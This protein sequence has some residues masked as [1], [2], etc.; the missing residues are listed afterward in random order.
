VVG[1]PTLTLFLYLSAIEHDSLEYLFLAIEVL[2]FRHR[3]SELILNLPGALGIAM[4]QVDRHH[5][6]GL[7]RGD[8]TAVMI[9]DVP[10]R[11]MCIACGPTH[12]RVE[13]R[14][15]LA[16]ISR[17]RGTAAMRVL[18]EFSTAHQLL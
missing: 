2:R 4:Q 11:A 15:D 8:V 10:G 9:G 1:T 6:Q 7:R 3:R 12:V 18:A 16:E 5:G 14:H 17:V 13:H